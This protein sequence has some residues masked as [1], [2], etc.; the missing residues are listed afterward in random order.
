[1]PTNK[2]QFSLVIDDELMEAI[3]DY[4]FGN[5]IKNRTTAINQL[6]HLGIQAI[7]AEEAEKQKAAEAAGAAPAAVPVNPVEAMT[8]LLC[9]AGI[10][11]SGD[12]ISGSD[13]AFLEAI[14]MA[15]EAHFQD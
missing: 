12:D 8:D 3:N 6:I 13:L 2:K 5:R 7:L 11:E 9:R 15:V 1:M 4:Q 10:I 14:F